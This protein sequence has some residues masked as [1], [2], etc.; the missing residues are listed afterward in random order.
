VRSSCV[1]VGSRV[2]GSVCGVKEGAGK[3]GT[4]VRSSRVA[5]GSRVEGS[6]GMGN[7]GVRGIVDM[8]R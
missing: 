2:E 1:G 8:V 4:R 7:A 5:V 6:V 3:G